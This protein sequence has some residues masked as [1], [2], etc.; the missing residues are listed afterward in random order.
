MAVGESRM[1]SGFSIMSGIARHGQR[2]AGQHDYRAAE[3]MTASNTP[4][5][6]QQGNSL[7]RAKS[8][9]VAAFPEEMPWQTT[10]MVWGGSLAR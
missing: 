4:L 2:V 8:E 10:N 7:L 1:A 3:G 6:R 9:S 5:R